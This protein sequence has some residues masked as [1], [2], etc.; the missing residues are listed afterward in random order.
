MKFNSL[1]LAI[2][3]LCSGLYSKAEVRTVVVPAGTLMTC[4]LDEPRFSSANV[5]LGDPFLCYPRNLTQFGQPVFPRGTYIV[6]HLEAD[7]DPGHFV[8]KGYLKLAFDRIGLPSGD[9]PITAKVVAVR[10]F[11]VDREGKIIGHGHATRDTVEWILPPFWPWKIL[12][13]PARGPR[14]TLKTE[15]RLTLR[16]MDDL[17]LPQMQTQT[18]PPG[19]HRFGEGSSSFPQPGPAF[20]PR[21]VSMEVKALPAALTVNE[22]VPRLLPVSQVADTSSPLAP[23]S[24]PVQAW[25]ANVTIFALTDGTLFPVTQYWR[26]RGELLYQ[27]EADTGTI[28][29]RSVDWSRTITLNAA[30]NVRVTLRNSPSGN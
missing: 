24:I 3:L 18:T 13:L 10:G 16:V 1:S 28:A 14:P 12:T 7:K 30:R 29:L 26:D 5:A 9:V 20:A 15:T 23:G 2:L 22:D 11:N 21:G 17:V 25:A 8:G 19:W 27:S 4:A 6:G